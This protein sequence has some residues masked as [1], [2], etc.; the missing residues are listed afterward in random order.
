MTDDISEERGRTIRQ[1]TN[2]NPLDPNDRSAT[3]VKPAELIDIVEMAP[4]SLFDRRT[5][6][7]MIAHAWDRIDEPIEHS[8]PKSILRGSHE[9]NDRLSD[10]IQRLMSVSAEVRIQRDGKRYLRS[11]H[12]LGTVARPEDEDED[13]NIYYEFPAELRGIIRQS[14]IFARL[15]T[16]VM[17]AFTSKYALALWEMI[18]RRGGMKDKR[19]EEFSPDEL[20]KL[21]GVPR[22]KLLGFSHFRQKVLVPAGDEVN[23]LS[24]Y[25]IEID[26]IRHGRKVVKL[27]L[28]W[29]PK[30]E[31]G[32]KAAYAEAGRHSAG[33]SARTAHQVER[34]VGPA[35]EVDQI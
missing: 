35:P 29:F 2:G 17:F 25:R 15:Q 23:A 21:L 32:L 6:N 19:T 26:A 1:R 3:M 10:T 16:E 4:L 27:R 20:R 24:S 8:L 22:G 12:L 9:S 7:L 5:Y 30:D 34:I 28:L 11:I 13:G 33:R 31:N 14:N 18:Q